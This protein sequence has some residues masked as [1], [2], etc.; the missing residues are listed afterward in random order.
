MILKN[1]ANPSFF[2][3]EANS[4]NEEID[5]LQQITHQSL[6]HPHFN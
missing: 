4:Q 5:L 6:Q 1:R 3:P 2:L